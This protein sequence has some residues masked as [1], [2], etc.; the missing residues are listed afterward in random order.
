MRSAAAMAT[1]LAFIGEMSSAAFVTFDVLRFP[2][3][4][5]IAGVLLIAE[6]RARN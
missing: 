5:L 2:W 4:V 1:R 3:H 6:E